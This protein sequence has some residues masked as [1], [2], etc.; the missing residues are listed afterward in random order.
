VWLAELTAFQR[1]KVLDIDDDTYPIKTHYRYF[2]LERHETNRHLSQLMSESIQMKLCNFFFLDIFFM[3]D[4]NL[5]SWTQSKNADHGEI[6]CCVVSSI[7]GK[8]LA[9]RTM[10]K[11]KKKTSS[12]LT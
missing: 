9:R 8:G 4:L 10:A 2:C 5:L 6:K 11:K 12:R 7:I 1:S 3:R